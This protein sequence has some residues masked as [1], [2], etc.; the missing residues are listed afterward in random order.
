MNHNPVRMSALRNY[1]APKFTK[2]SLSLLALGLVF[3]AL[4]DNDFGNLIRS[5]IEFLSEVHLVGIIFVAL[6]V[7]FAGIGWLQSLLYVTNVSLFSGNVAAERSSVAMFALFAFVTIGFEYV[8][9]V[10]MSQEPGLFPQILTFYF[11][12]YLMIQVYFVK[13]NPQEFSK[14]IDLERVMRR[15]DV[16][17]M[18][19]LLGLVYSYFYLITPT[20]PVSWVIALSSALII[21]NLVAGSFVLKRR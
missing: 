17:V 8:I 10:V 12:F 15:T 11:L 13:D 3:S 16:V 18:I 6:L 20:Q 5:L 2:H 7:V 19:T 14:S 1:F 4:F 21:W 9:G